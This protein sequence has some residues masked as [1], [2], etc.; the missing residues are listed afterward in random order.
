[1]NLKDALHHVVAGHDLSQADARAAMRS[2]VPSRCR[3][4]SALVEAA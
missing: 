1:M 4:E 2:L 3:T